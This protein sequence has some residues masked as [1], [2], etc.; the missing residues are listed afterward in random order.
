MDYLKVDHDNV[1]GLDVVVNFTIEEINNV[2]KADLTQ[3]L[4][5][6]LF[7]PG[8][9]TSVTELKAKIKEELGLDPSSFL[10]FN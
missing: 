7:G 4:F 5:D 10:R 1:H 3:E 2:E 9:V 8:V 6:K